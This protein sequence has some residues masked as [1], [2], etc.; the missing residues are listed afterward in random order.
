MHIHILGICGTFMGGIAMLAR[1]LGHQVT[2]SDAN[3]YP[4]MSTLLEKQGID[5]IQGYDPSQLTPRPDLVIVGNAMGRG[6]PCV[7]TVLEEGIPYASGPQ[8]LHDNVLRERWVI[9]IAGTH[10]K[11]TTSGM[12]TWILESCGYNPGF[13]I[14]GVPGNF[15]VSARLGD[16]PFFVIEADE[17]DTAFFDKRSKF[18]HYC[19]RTL[20][21][22]NLEFDHA[23]IFEDLHAIQKQFHHLVRLVPGKGKIILPENDANLKQVLSMGCWSEL[24][25]SGVGQRWSANKLTADAGQFEVLFDDQV[26]GEVNWSLVGEHNMHNGLMAVAAARHVGVKPEDACRAL[27]GFINARR[28]LEF[29]GEVNGVSVYDD[30]AHHPTAILATLA[31]LRSKVGGTA[32]ILAVLEPRSNTMKMGVSKDE[33]APAFGRA[34]EVFI[35]QPPTLA[36]QVSDVTDA[37]I[38]PAHWTGDVDMLVSMIV[39]SAQPGDNILVMSNGGFGGIHGKLLEALEKKALASY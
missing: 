7:E 20:V 1:S 34:D 10:G 9:A 21:L 15:D 28:R 27:G 36:W 29:K 38:Q 33:L 12:V 25:T 13:V 4:P 32:R 30:F 3:V 6:N 14:G 2:G 37:C 11:T 22:N 16:S 39:N 35:L 18:V 5:L 8:W 24:E 19:P 26:V 31:A 17:Y 23:D